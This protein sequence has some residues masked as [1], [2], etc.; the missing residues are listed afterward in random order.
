MRSTANLCKPSPVHS[1]P[2]VGTIIVYNECIKWRDRKVSR[3]ERGC[4]LVVGETDCLITLDLAIRDSC[5]I[6]HTFLKSDFQLG[7]F[8][9]AE[10]KEVMFLRSCSYEDYNLKEPN[11]KLR[12]LLKL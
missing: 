8:I 2:K 5:Y 12:D 11:E 7:I 9:F 6:R 3:E 10:V 1:I 4:G